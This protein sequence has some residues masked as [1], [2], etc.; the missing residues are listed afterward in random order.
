MR[1]RALAEREEAHRRAEEELRAAVK[2]RESE[3]KAL[4]FMQ[5]ARE[6][7]E[8]LLLRQEKEKR[9]KEEQELE[10]KKKKRQQQIII[11]AH[12]KAEAERLRASKAS[13]L[14]D[15]PIVKAPPNKEA[16]S[17]EKRTPVE[18][19]VTPL[20][21]QVRLEW[22]QGQE[23]IRKKETDAACTP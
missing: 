3:E 15:Q 23:A 10:E 16:L 22:E 9:D 13:K 17:A 19:D 11:A 5:K 8:E 4:F 18:D 21:R 20:E 7:E 14:A 12:Y 1:E 2:A 6:R